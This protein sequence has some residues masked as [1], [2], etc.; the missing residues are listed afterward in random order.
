MFN[1]LLPGVAAIAQAFNE[2]VLKKMGEINQT[3]L[4]FALSNP[5]SKAECTAEQA[6]KA[7]DGRCIFACGSPFEPVTINGKTHLPGQG[8]NAY[9]FPGVALA[10]M[11]CQVHEIPNEVFLAA[12]FALAD[13]VAQSDLDKGSVY[14]PL[15]NIYEVSLRIAQRTAE[16]LYAEGYAHHRPEPNDKLLFLKSRLYDASYDGSNFSEHVEES[17]KAWHENWHQTVDSFT[18]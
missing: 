4:I 6:Y 11:A 5:T 13:Q 3:P 14:P 10:V 8:N 1:F 7:T 16:W 12:A 17:Q 2:K 18:K 9:I 15:E